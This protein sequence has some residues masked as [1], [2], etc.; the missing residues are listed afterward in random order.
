[1]SP[2]KRRELIDMFDEKVADYITASVTL[3]IAMSFELK[4]WVRLACDAARMPTAEKLRVSAPPIVLPLLA[5][6]E[7][8]PQGNAKHR[9]SNR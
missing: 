3:F 4:G 9:P 2:P 8:R 6:A 5:R 7:G 1:M